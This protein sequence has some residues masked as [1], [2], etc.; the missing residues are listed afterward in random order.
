M[1]SVFSSQGE[2]LAIEGFVT[3][4]TQRKQFEQSLQESEERFRRL[5]EATDEGILIHDHG[6]IIDANQALAK[7]FGYETDELIGRSG[8]KLLVP[9][10]RDIALKQIQAAYVE[11]YEVV[12]LSK[13]GSQFPVEIQAKLIPYQNR[14][15]RVVAIRDISRRQQIEKNYGK[16]ETS[17]EPFWM[18]YLGVLVGLV[19][20]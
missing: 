12:G 7:M 16:P 6:M 9:E 2:V 14:L 5:S 10:S 1:W 8:F 13:D 4:I 17:Y 11:P 15:V 3:D 19:P 18:P 20:I